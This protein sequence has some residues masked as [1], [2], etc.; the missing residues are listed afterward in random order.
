M[1]RKSTSAIAALTVGM[2]A[3]CNVQAASGEV[4]VAE[5]HDPGGKL[6]GTLTVSQTADHGVVI[7]ASFIAGALPKG[8]HGFHVHA[9]GKCS[10]DFAA[11]GDHFDHGGHQHGELAANGPHAGDL[12]NLHLPETGPHTVEIFAPYLSLKPGDPGNLLDDDGSA[13]VVHAEPDDYESQ[14][15]GGAGDRIACGVVQQAS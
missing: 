13:F 2:M 9:V 12:P 1:P 4:A 11:A 10:P 7:A 15:S 8:R 14:P 3:S 5:L 6:V